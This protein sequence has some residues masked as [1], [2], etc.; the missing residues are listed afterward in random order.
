[1]RSRETLLRLHRFRTEDRRRQAADIDGMIQDLTK[2]YD[3]LDS[4]VRFEES[5]NGVT[6]PANVNYS[7]AAKAT[8]GRRDNLLKSISDLKDQKAAVLEQLADEEVELRKV[9]MLMEKESGTSS[10]ASGSS[11]LL[12][13]HAH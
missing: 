2:K 4:H 13:A 10:S 7:M 12:A 11:S 1:M 8:R 3:E 9:E 5:R 6:D